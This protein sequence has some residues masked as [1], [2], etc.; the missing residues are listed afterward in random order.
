MSFLLLEA[1]DIEKYFSNVQILNV[2]NF[3]IYSGDRLGFVGANGSGKT[4]F[5][6]ILSGE[7][8]P[9]YGGVSRYCDIAYIRQFGGIADKDYGGSAQKLGEYGVLDKM[10]NPVISGG[11]KT[12]IKIAQAFSGNHILIFADEP[13]SNLDINGIKLFE[14]E[15]AQYESFILIS[16]DRDLLNKYCN[17]IMA[18]ENFNIV[19]YEGNYDAYKSQID[20]IRERALF[21]YEQYAGEK[22]RL[23]T[24]FKD[25]KIKAEKI[26]KKPG[27]MSSSEIKQRDFVAT[28]R[29]F[30]G[31]QKRA[32]QAAKAVQSRIDQMDVKEKPRETPTMKLDFNL[33]DP[34]R[35][36]LIFTGKNISYAYG[37]NV[38][39]K[40]AEFE[41]ANG[42]KVAVQ[43]ANGS[44]KTTFLNLVFNGNFNLAPKVKIGYYRQDFEQLDM[45]KTVLQNAVADSVQPETAVRSVLA[46]LLFNRDAINKTAGVLSGGERVKLSLAKLLV[47]SCNALLL[48]E[49]TNY[50][51]L[52]SL[53][54]LQSILREYEG[55]LMFVSHDRAFVDAVHTESLLIRGHKLVRVIK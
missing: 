53:E 27:N 45:N 48:D 4:T 21:E 10:E 18:I 9:D 30:D 49:P 26:T 19:I 40:D 51:D 39:F 6:N 50:L 1:R 15:L 38:L 11:E 17:R 33:T 16:H 43:G 13:T 12:R 5:L 29:S 37:E 55:T 46:R 34:P 52:P 8:P 42:A 25:K 20:A 54:I 47:S 2:K 3:K 41:V 7:T 23:N 22:E 36:K 44:G 14:T 31:R 35:G 24:V 28:S 32:D